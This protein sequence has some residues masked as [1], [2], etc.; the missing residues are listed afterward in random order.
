[1]AT[2]QEIRD[3]A[4]K[5][6]SDPDFRQKLVEDPESAFVEA[7]V[8]LDPKQLEALKGIDRSK[9]EDSLSNLDERLNM[10]V[11]MFWRP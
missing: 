10:M 5:A 6:L 4:G 7:G 2:E 11:R 9:I 1:M 3:I 8:E